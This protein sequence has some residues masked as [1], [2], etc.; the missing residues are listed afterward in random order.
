[1]VNA[2]LGFARE[3]TPVDAAF[4]TPA[5]QCLGV[6]VNHMPAGPAL[7]ALVTNVVEIELANAARDASLPV[8]RRQRAVEAVVWLAKALIMRG[9][10]CFSRMGKLLCELLGA[11]AAE[12]SGV[13]SEGFDVLFKESPGFEGIGFAGALY[14]QRFFHENLAWFLERP[15]GLSP[16]AEGARLMG[17]GS[18]LR[19]LP[20]SIIDT[21]LDTLLPLMLQSIA[22][23]FPKLRL[24][25]LQTMAS[26]LT[27]NPNCVTA[28]L[29]TAVPRIL[30][31]TAFAEEPSMHARFLAL[32]CLEL[33]TTLPFHVLFP[34]K[35]SVTEGLA[36]PLD[37]SK[38]V[39][40]KQAVRARNEW[41]VLSDGERD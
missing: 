12:V 11:G 25:T 2:L 16:A 40:R 32:K 36:A 35:L 6:V 30:N 10:S 14:K 39:V 26:L 24:A 23:E 21:H 27:N 33:L 29:S 38:R 22:S 15:A 7:D 34:F 1:V 9:H 37:D 3:P 41:Y 28:H 20:A 18:M 17:L 5:L 13:A 31:R 4:A 8:E 19:H